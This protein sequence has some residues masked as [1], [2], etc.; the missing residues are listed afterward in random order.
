MIDYYTRKR[1]FTLLCDTARQRQALASVPRWTDA[2]AI[3]FETIDEGID[4][5]VKWFKDNGY[6]MGQLYDTFGY[7]HN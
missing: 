2:Q 3:Q 1:L 5:L 6:T 4:T 7:P